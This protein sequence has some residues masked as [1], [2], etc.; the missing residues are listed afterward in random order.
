M[1]RIGVELEER[2]ED[3]RRGDQRDEHYRR[4]FTEPESRRNRVT[5]ITRLARHALGDRDD[6]HVRR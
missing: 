6:E 3:Y 4:A 5:A 1:Q 2:P